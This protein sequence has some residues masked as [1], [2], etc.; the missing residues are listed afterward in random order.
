MEAKRHQEL[1]VLVANTSEHCAKRKLMLISSQTK[2]KQSH[3]QKQK[4]C[5]QGNLKADARKKIGGSVVTQ[6]N[7]TWHFG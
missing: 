3:T 6:F 2:I 5:M 7:V 4:R 1:T